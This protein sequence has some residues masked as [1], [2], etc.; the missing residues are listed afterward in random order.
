MEICW[1]FSDRRSEDV[2]VVVAIV[3]RILRFVVLFSSR[4]E[5][6]T[7]NVRVTLTAGWQHKRVHVE[8]RADDVS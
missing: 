5:Q 7:R 6:G 8:R 2:H 3:E 1:V 4:G